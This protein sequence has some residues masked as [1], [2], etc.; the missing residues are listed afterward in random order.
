MTMIVPVEGAE[1]FCSRRG[2]GPA[3]LVL[4]GIGSRPYERQIPARLTE[5]LTLIHV[6]LRGSGRS[7]GEAADLTFDVLAEDLEAVRARLGL[8]RIAVLGHSILGAL[9]IEYGRR[10]PEVVSH[11]IVVGTPPSGDMP[12]LL[13]RSGSFFEADASPERKSLL[14]DNLAKLGPGASPRETVLA[15]AP[16]R[17]FDAGFD[18]TPLFAEADIQPKFLPHVMGT[19]TRAWDVTAGGDPLRVP[20]LIAHGRY[21][22]T[23]PHI[24]WDGIVPTLPTA[25]FRLFAR[26]GHQ[27]FFE[28]PEVFTAAL[29]SW[30]S[31]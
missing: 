1:L 5:R 18:P 8:D 30:M 21:D 25:T 20:L 9:A 19:L 23:V 2:H 3:C 17:F 16:L 15:Q 12:Q 28:E 26:S 4:S 14:R 6:D 7:T 10:R 22:Y 27:P 29:L 13:A 11:V 31:A 24:L